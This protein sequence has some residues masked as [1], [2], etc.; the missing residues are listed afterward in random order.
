MRAF[1]YLNED[2]KIRGIHPG[3]HFMEN[4]AST[5]LNRK[6][7]IMN[8]KYQSVPLS[9][10]RANNAERESD[11]NIQEPLHSG[12]FQ[13][14]KIFSSSIMV[15][16]LTAGNTQSKPAQEINNPSPHISLY[17]HLRII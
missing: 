16:T 15:Q 4:E 11:S 7:K 5:A 10:H 6:M 14:R 3:F 17:S 9:N 12:T 1:K 2:L 8:I 13:R